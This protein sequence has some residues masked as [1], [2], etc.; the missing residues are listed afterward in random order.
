MSEIKWKQVSVKQVP[1]RGS[2]A[3][4]TVGQGRVSLS[5]SAC[6]MIEDIYEYNYIEAHAGKVNDITEKIGLRF[7]KTK[8]PNSLC[9]SRR[10]YKNKLV[11]GLEVRSKA[12]IAEFYGK[13][14]DN[15]STRHPVEIIDDT[16]IAIDI[17][18]EL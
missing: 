16:M 2:E 1:G 18:R 13:T 11:G 6:N 12:L 5:A 3:F 10:K 7:S 8:T 14:K 4:A 17:T 15:K 9:Y